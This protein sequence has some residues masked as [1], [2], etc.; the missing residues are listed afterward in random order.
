MASC[1]M[2][3]T[4]YGPS[5]RLPTTLCTYLSLFCLFSYILDSCYSGHSGN[6][7]TLRQSRSSVPGRHI[8]WAAP[9]RQGRPYLSRL[10]PCSWKPESSEPL[11]PVYGPLC[12]PRTLHCHREP[13]GG[14]LSCL[15]HSRSHSRSGY[16]ALQ[17]RH[18]V[19][20]DHCAH[21]ILLRVRPRPAG[22]S[23]HPRLLASLVHPAC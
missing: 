5:P 7:V 9:S 6:S 3:P 16:G 23:D 12:N 21:Q 19:Y 8:S 20:G 2:T 13:R 22:P 11:R 4:A 1:A 10:P 14:T 17:Q 18:I 15:P